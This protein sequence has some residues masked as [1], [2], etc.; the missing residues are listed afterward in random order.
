MG[1]VKVR[2]RMEQELSEAA[3]ELRLHKF[4]IDEHAIVA[5]TDPRGVISYVN[6]KF[7]SISKYSREELI[8]RTHRVINSGQH[9]K[10]FFVDMWRTIASGRTWHGE[11]CN[12]AKD[13]QLYWVDTTIVPFRGDDGVI[14]Q[15]VAIRADITKRKLAE[16]RLAETNDQLSRTNDE[17][18]RFVYTASH[19][20]KSPIVTIRG[21]LSHLRE[22]L[23][24]GRLDRAEEFMA[25]IDKASLKMRESIDA[26]LELSRVGRVCNEPRWVDLGEAVREVVR[27]H[28]LEIERLG[29]SVRVGHDLGFVRIDPHRLTEILDNLV[30]NAV[31]YGCDGAGPM[32]SIG[33]E[34]RAGQ[35]CF[36]VRDTGCGIPLEYQQKVFGIFERLDT[37]K[38]GSGIGLAIVKKIVEGIG[39]RIWI[40]SSPGEGAAFWVVFPQMAGKRPTEPGGE[41]GE[42][43]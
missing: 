19:D 33:M 2:D 5:I 22:D 8:G 20:L 34:T 10:M 36:C 32:I 37:A 3:S 39:G 9:T 38:E 28:E 29:I 31:K 42:I 1:A 14:K 40:D 23:G 17:L 21:F 18:E 12:R 30:S 16:Q 13:G 43:A 25:R 15:Y 6:D 4:A 27:D 41:P 11:I 7:C 26:L 35:R 24:Q